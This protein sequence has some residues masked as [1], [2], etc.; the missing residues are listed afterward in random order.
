[1][2][3]NLLLIV[4]V[5]LEA[6]QF[7]LFF[8]KFSKH[9][10]FVTS[11]EIDPSKVKMLSVN[12]HI[13]GCGDNVFQ[14]TGDFLKAELQKHDVAFVSPPWGGLG[15]KDESVFSLKNQ[16]TPDIDEILNK[17]KETACDEFCFYMP[18]NISYYEMCDM[19]A[20]HWDIKTVNITFE[21]LHSANKV[22]A[23]LVTFKPEEGN[24][25]SQEL[26]KY[27]EA[28]FKLKG[29]ELKESVRKVQKVGVVEFLETELKEK[30]KRKGN[31]SITQ[32]FKSLEKRSAE[33]FMWLEAKAF[34]SEPSEAEFMERLIS[35]M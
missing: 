3:E 18:R 20:N 21:K 17:L 24:L 32:V 6:T 11:V 13:Y 34:D 2:Q 29:K 7:R 15:Y 8:K 16:I 27:L 35:F 30:K 28:R 10:T 12:S 9:C 14:L 22:K 25:E 33:E 23:I 26:S 5:E 4:S 31:F 1:M 19:I